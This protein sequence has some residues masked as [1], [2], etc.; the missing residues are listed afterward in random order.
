MATILEN[1]DTLAQIKSDIKEALADKGVTVTDDFTT[2][3]QGVEDISTGGGGGSF[4]TITEAAYNALAVK[5]PSTAY[6]IYG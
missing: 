4:V 5:D 3:A 2:Y 6:L 1:L